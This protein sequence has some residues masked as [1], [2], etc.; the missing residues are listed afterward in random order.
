MG[1]FGDAAQMKQTVSDTGDKHLLQHGRSLLVGKEISEYCLL[2][3]AL[4]PK[5]ALWSP[6]HL[7]IVIG[8]LDLELH[9]GLINRLSMVNWKRNDWHLQK[10]AFRLLISGCNDG[11]LLQVT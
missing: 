8:S 9:I 7:A 3:P 1:K 4:E 2:I 10:K 6:A 11:G 5:Y